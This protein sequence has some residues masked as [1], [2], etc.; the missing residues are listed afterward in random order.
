LGEI[1]TN[2]GN[3][4]RFIKEE[5]TN[6]FFIG[7]SNFHTNRA[8]VYTIEAARMLNSG[9]NDKMAA[10]LLGM[11]IEEIV[12]QT[13]AFER[14]QGYD[15]PD[16]EKE[17]ADCVRLARKNY[18]RRKLEAEGLPKEEV[19]KQLADCEEDGE[20]ERGQQGE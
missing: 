9:C 7:C 16:V 15:I 6:E 14:Y 4:M 2:F 8:L 5:D 11:A 12:E 3:A 1:F 20:E 18:W 19:T 17:L 10:Q 13:E